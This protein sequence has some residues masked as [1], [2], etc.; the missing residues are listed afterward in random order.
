M[1]TVKAVWTSRRLQHALLDRT[2]ARNLG[3]ALAATVN[4]VPYAPAPMSLFMA[5]CDGGPPTM[6]RLGAPDQGVDQGPNWP[7]GQL[8]E[9]NLTFSLLISPYN[10]NLTYFIFFHSIADQCIERALSSRSVAIRLNSYNAPLCFETDSQLG[11]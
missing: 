8:V 6:E 10:L 4:L 2:R 9:I 11:P 1:A 5:L 3:G 7:L